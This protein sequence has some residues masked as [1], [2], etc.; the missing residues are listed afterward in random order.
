MGSMAVHKQLLSEESEPRML[1]LVDMA[2]EESSQ[3]LR[4]TDHAG[5]D[6]FPLDIPGYG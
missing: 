5:T 4:V 6:L 3:P 2:K 1:T